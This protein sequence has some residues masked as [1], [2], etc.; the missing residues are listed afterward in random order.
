MVF[1]QGRMTR[2]LTHVHVYYPELWPEIK[3]CLGS[4]DAGT[5]DLYVTMVQ[6]YPDLV[7]DIKAFAPDAHCLVV[8]NRGYDVGPFVHVLGL[9]DL[10]AYDYVI[11]LHTKRDMPAGALLGAF[12]MS[13]ATWRQCALAFLRPRAHLQACL[14][15]F[16]NN[17]SIG[18]MAHHRL[19]VGQRYGDKAALRACQ[20]LCRKMGWPVRPFKYV[21]GTMFIMRARLLKPVV[22]MNL[23]FDDFPAPTQDKPTT[24]AHVLERYFGYLVYAQNSTIQDGFT[25]GYA[26]VQNSLT[27]PFCYIWHFIYRRKETRSG[28]IIIKI[29]KIPVYSKKS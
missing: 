9:I 15:G 28:N 16:A 10:N 13:G 26:Q 24:L 21:A 19:I 27:K 14:Q 11:K 25:R 2:I 7:T 1:E 22:E 17:P 12:N 5:Y 3:A 23:T 6:D 18:M 29:C 4:I 20:D 8:A